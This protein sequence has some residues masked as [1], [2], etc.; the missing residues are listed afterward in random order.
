MN[1]KARTRSATASPSNNLFHQLLVLIV[2]GILV[3]APVMSI[4]LPDRVPEVTLS[5]NQPLKTA[6]FALGSF[7]RSE[8]V[9]G[10][11]KG[12]VRTT[13]GYCGGSKLDPEYRSLADHAE[14]VQVLSLIIIVCLSRSS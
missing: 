8:A 4:R 9:F 10:C 6:V 13:V 1:W 14:S 12:V 2:A 5:T 7:W 3:P 11:L